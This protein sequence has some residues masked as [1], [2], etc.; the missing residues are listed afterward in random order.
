MFDVHK[1]REDFPI[2]KRRINDNPLVYL[3]NAATTQKPQVVIEAVSDF[4]RHSNANVHRGAHTISAEAT[5]I[6]ENARQRVAEFINAADKEIIFV[7]NATEAIN[8]AAYGWARHNLQPGDEIVLTLLEHHSNIVPWQLI[9]AETGARLRYVQPD[10][11]GELNPGAFEEQLSAKTVLL[12]FTGM[13][14]ALGTVPDSVQ[15]VDL[16]RRFE[17]RVLVDAAQMAAHMPLD[18]QK[19][20]CDFLAFSGHKMCGPTGIGVL[21]AGEEVMEEMQPLFGGGEMIGKVGLE[22]STWAALPHRFEAGTPSIAQAAGL[23]VAIDYIDRLG[24]EN[25]FE[26]EQK[27]VKKAEQ[28]LEQI[29]GVEIYG[30]PSCRSGALSFNIKGIHP[31]DLA[32]ILDAAGV[33]IRAGHHC[34][35]PLMKFIDQKSTARASFYF[36]NTE[37][38]VETFAAALKEAGEY[39]NNVTG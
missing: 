30:N 17:A 4:Y 24:M 25:I 7:R 11:N 28:Q 27:L 23:K 32:Q 12:T 21:Y 35:Q 14:N 13:S 33:A 8:L 26:H 16:A 2:L 38:E 22:S 20:G 31:H 39:F 6:Y 1:V 34:A 37:Q 18:V 5:D 3:D 9:A 15:L 10:E 19:L 29:E 36:Y